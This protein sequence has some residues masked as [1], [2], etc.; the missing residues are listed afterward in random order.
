MLNNVIVGKVKSMKISDYFEYRK[1]EYCYLQLIVTKSNRNNNTE[2]IA[3][4][5]NKMFK[6]TN[7]YISQASKRL[8]IEER[9]KASFYIHITKEKVQFYFMIPKTYYQILH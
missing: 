2:Q 3:L 6:K 1:C 5:I 4:L 7:K 8:I 9:P